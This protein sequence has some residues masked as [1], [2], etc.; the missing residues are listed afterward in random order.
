M[1]S[2]T[3]H[4]VPSSLKQDGWWLGPITRRNQPRSKT[5]NPQKSAR[6]TIHTLLLAGLLAVAHL[7]VFQDTPNQP[8]TF[9][10]NSHSKMGYDD[11]QELRSLT[12]LTKLNV[13]T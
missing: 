7:S 12:G 5:R 3:L 8:S 2:R 9:S 4:G 11:G 10:C 13:A 6:Y 1:K